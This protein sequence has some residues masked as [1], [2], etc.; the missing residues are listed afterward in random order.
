VAS[1]G[2]GVARLGLAGLGLAGL[3]LSGLGLAGLGLAGLGL[4]GTP[5]IRWRPPTTP[6]TAVLLRRRLC[7]PH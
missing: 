4:S 7:L 6:F 2:L 3:G 5:R 1:L